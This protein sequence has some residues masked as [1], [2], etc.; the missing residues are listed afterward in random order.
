MQYLKGLYNE[1]HLQCT[2]SH[3]HAL[4]LDL[5]KGT[6]AIN[7]VGAE[8]KWGGISF[9]CGG[10]SKFLIFFSWRRTFDIHLFAGE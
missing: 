4:L 2:V 9:P 7:D 6:S 5:V 1:D 8:K 10:L 3:S